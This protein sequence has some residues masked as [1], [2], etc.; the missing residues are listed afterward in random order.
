MS[1]AGA[2]PDAPTV[3]TIPATEFAPM[4]S[5]PLHLD[6]TLAARV[7]A[8]ARLVGMTP[9]EYLRDA[10]AR[11]VEETEWALQDLADIAGT[12]A[13]PNA[14]PGAPAS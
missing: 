11:S 2:G 13:G 14:N 12:S 5:T 7:A 4:E 9:H 10:I 8:A 1:G 6:D 3:A